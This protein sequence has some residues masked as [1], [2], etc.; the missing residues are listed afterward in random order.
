MSG[1]A[2]RGQSMVEA[3]MAIPFLLFLILGA[4]E[5]G[6]IFT[7]NLTIEY[8]TREGARVGSAL[9]NG[10]GPLG[11]GAGKSPNAASVDPNIIAAIERVLEGSGSPIQ[12]AQVGEIRIFKATAT[13]GETP[14]IV[15]VWRYNPGGGPVVGGQ[16]L[17]FSQVSVGWSACF[18]TNTQPA[19]SIGIAMR[20]R[21]DFQTPFLALAG[22]SSLT[23]NDRTVMA[24]N[25]TGQ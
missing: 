3:A 8:A 20:Y 14:G 5:F 22:V 18:R 9:A 13:G 21:Y 4:V 17:D 11:C 16:R 24:L 2:E 1:R 12:P 6:F 23:M 7:N 15:N 19:D 10:G 25:P